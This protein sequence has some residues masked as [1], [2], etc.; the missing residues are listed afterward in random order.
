MAGHVSTLTSIE[1]QYI[2]VN[3]P[4]DPAQGLLSLYLKFRT[5]K[6]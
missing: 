5:F 6:L 1:Y 2:D 3:G 4:V